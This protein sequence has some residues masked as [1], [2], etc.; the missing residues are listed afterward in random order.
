MYL[1]KSLRTITKTKDALYNDIAI[2]FFTAITALSN[3]NSILRLIILF[4]LFLFNVF[5]CGYW[6]CL[7]VRTFAGLLSSGLPLHT[8]G[9][10]S[11][12]AV[13]N[14]VLLHFLLLLLVVLLLLLLVWGSS[15]LLLHDLSDSWLVIHRNGSHRLSLLLR[16]ILFFLCWRS[17]LGTS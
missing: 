6:M 12:C 14:Y 9:R 15:G 3:L 5:R 17:L 1:V 2:F 4:N 11:I 10:V 13:F 7:L 16:A 8:F